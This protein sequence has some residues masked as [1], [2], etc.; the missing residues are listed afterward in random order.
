MPEISTCLWFDD[1][2]MEAVEFYTTVFPNSERRGV[3]HYEDGRVLAAEWTLDGRSFRG[4]NG[5]PVHAGFTE[6]VSL[7]ISCADQSEVDY[8]WDT[9]VA[10]GQP[11][12]CAW[13]KD[14]FGLSWQVVPVRLYEL[15]SDPDPLRAQAAVAAMMTQQKIII[16]DIEAAAD[17][18]APIRPTPATPPDP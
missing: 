4:I 18:A 12:Q 11:D 7:S 1:D 17:A 8:Y 9:L 2:L 6:T 10:G 15:I 3:S 16:A 5:G 14:K 13:L